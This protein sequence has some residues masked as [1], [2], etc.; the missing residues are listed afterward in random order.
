MKIA[1]YGDSFGSS[2]IESSVERK[3]CDTRGKAWVELLADNYNVTNFSY[4]GSSLFYS[5]QLFLE[6]NQKFNYNIFLITSQDRIT[7][8]DDFDV[9]P[10]Y[11]HINLK[12]VQYFRNQFL[13]QGSK[14]SNL[15]LII[16]ALESY[17]KIIHNEQAVDIYHNLMI[18]NIN[19]INQN[20]IIIPCFNHSIP[21]TPFSLNLISEY[22]FSDSKVMKTLTHNKC[23]DW[24]IIEDENGKWTF[25]D[26]RKCHLNEENNKILFNLIEKAIINKQQT[27]NL[28]LNQFSKMS[29]DIE[30]YHYLI[31]LDKPWSYLNESRLNGELHNLYNKLLIDTN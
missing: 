30:F 18:E 31:R 27:I 13:N 5:Y 4:P 21:N 14:D 2:M 1:I 7:L 16:F 3:D 12:L 26:Y 25:N 24:T 28:D 20:T 15:D 23:F 11:K 19:R 10:I 9:K 17:Y 29:K 6:Y 8:P 22:E